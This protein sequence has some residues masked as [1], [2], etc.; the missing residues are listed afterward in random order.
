MFVLLEGAVVLT[1]VGSVLVVIRFVERHNT[2]R[3]MGVLAL[4]FVG[5]L[6][7]SVVFFLSG[8]RA[9][10][11]LDALRLGAVC[12]ISKIPWTAPGQNW[13]FF[14]ARSADLRR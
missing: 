8:F 5:A 10:V 2:R 4:K 11:R 13:N 3:S 12:A 1:K 6:L 14:G 9:S 7:Q